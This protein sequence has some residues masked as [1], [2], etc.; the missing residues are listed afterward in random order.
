MIEC[1]TAYNTQKGIECYE[2]LKNEGDSGTVVVQP[3][4]TGI[5]YQLIPKATADQIPVFSMGYGRTSATNGRVFP[6][7]FNFPASY[8]D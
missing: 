6:W 5:T 1:E 3:L 7:I 4:S 2:S 8:W